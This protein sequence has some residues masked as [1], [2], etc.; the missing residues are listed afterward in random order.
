MFCARVCES[1]VFFG[2][3]REEERGGEGG[4]V[5]ASTGKTTAAHVISC[6]ICAMC[7]AV[8]ISGAFKTNYYARIQD[9]RGWK[10]KGV[11]LPTTSPTFKKH[12]TATSIYALFSTFDWG[13]CR[14]G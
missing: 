7:V 9:G 1:A 6:R 3:E 8:S 11:G 4:D 12:K 13:L 2:T 14:G 5:L 10:E